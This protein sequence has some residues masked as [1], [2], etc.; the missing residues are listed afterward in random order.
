MRDF[1]IL[2]VHLIA[3]VARLA[4]PGGI[5]SLVAE[6][7]LVKHQL[8]ILNRSR[9]RAVVR[10]NFIRAKSGAILFR[11]SVKTLNSTR[12]ALRSA[13]IT[14]GGKLLTRERHDQGTD[15]LLAELVIGMRTHPPIAE[16]EADVVL[17]VV[18]HST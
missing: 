14:L 1:V 7:V 16:T 17:P 8:L 3:T 13:K 12:M 6:S 4:G 18:L 9:K 2:F 5:R 15:H 10:Q 11:H